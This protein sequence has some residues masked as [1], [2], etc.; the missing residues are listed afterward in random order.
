[1]FMSPDAT[2]ADARPAPGL[3][4]MATAGCLAA[5]LAVMVFPGWVIARL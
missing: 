5:A 2:V 4:R 1:M 3:A